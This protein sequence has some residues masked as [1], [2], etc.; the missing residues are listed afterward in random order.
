MGTTLEIDMT[1][2]IGLQATRRNIEGVVWKR[3]ITVDLAIMSPALV[4]PTE[5]NVVKLRV[6]KSMERAAS[7]PRLP[8]QE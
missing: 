8:V 2:C 3:P 6:M 5:S 1:R 4:V 7:S